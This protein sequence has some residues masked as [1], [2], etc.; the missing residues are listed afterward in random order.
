M[1]PKPLLPFSLLPVLTGGA[2][3]TPKIVWCL[4]SQK[5]VNCTRNLA[6]IMV[7]FLL[8]WQS[9]L[10]S[11]SLERQVVAS[12]GAIGEEGGITLSWTVGEAVAGYLP[13]GAVS[14]SQGFQQGELLLNPTDV[15]EVFAR[16]QVKVYP[17]PTAAIL[18]LEAA[19]PRP[20]ETWQVAMFSA[21][22]RQVSGGFRVWPNGQK[23]FSMDVR[24]LPAG[25]YYLRLSGKG[26]SGILTMPFQKLGGH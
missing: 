8:G 4:I 2:P 6:K 22:G 26:R 12:G 24:A 23:Q 10:H 3:R 5:A 21:A 19:E 9:L 25:Q 16:L 18:H 13:G 14:L 11:Q 1:I 17:N 15:E 7:L 20:E